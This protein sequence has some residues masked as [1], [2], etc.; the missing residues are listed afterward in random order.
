M[1]IGSSSPT[2]VSRASFARKATGGIGSATATIRMGCWLAGTSQKTSFAA[3][4]GSLLFV[5]VRAHLWIQRRYCDTEFAWLSSRVGFPVDAWISH[6]SST[7]KPNER[8]Q[9]Q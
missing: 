8:Y 5:R 9:W 6:K 4:C 7:L 2:T 3:G 1:V